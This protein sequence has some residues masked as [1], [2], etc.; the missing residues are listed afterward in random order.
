MAY[1]KMASLHR[2]LSA[3]STS[4]QCCTQGAI[5]HV[6][7]GT[8]AHLEF[9]RDHDDCAPIMIDDAQFAAVLKAFVPEGMNERNESIWRAAFIVGGSSVFLGLVREREEEEEPH[10]E[11]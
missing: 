5:I 8:R 6:S 1:Q 11:A 3:A 7:C 10:G 4:R 2:H 9:I